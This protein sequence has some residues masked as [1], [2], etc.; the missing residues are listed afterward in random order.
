MEVRFDAFLLEDARHEVEFPGGDA[1]GEDQDVGGAQPLANQRPKA[2]GAVPADAEVARSGAGAG[3]LRQQ[4]GGIAVANLS[5]AWR[6]RRL[7]ELVSRGDH[8]DQRRRMQ[9]DGGSAHRGQDAELLRPEDGTVRQDHFSLA[10]L[11]AAGKNVLPG[12]RRLVVYCD[13]VRK[14]AGAFDHHNR[15]SPL[16]DG[17]PVMMRVASPGLRGSRGVCPAKT[18][19]TTRRTA[20][21]VG[22]SPAAHG[23]AVH[24]RLVEGRH[25]DVAGDGFGENAAQRLRRERRRLG[26]QGPAL[27]QD[28]T[29]SVDNGKHEDGL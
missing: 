18:S 6:Q 7:D 19:S 29:A 25:I 27:R 22:R 9:Q 12:P 17:A 28:A 2:L 10:H 23:I 8:R 26:R 1:A 5:R 4:H 24:H 3:G 16:G 21:P 15:I 13:L 20:L 11:P 14:Q